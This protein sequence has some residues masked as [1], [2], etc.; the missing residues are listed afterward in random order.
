MIRRFLGAL[1][2]ALMDAPAW[3]LALLILAIVGY[4]LTTGGAS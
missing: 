2:G 1:L 3:V 4:S